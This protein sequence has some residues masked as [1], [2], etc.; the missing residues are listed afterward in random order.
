MSIVGPGGTGTTMVIGLAAGQVC[1]DAG[2]APMHSRIA[3]MA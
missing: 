2:A 3:A 1:A